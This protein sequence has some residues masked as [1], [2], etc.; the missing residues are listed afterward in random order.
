MSV[1][2]A[3]DSYYSENWPS[4]K[5]QSRFFRLRRSWKLLEIE[6]E[7]KSRRRGRRRSNSLKVHYRAI[8][9]PV[10][11]Q[12]G[13]GSVPGK[14]KGLFFY[15]GWNE[16]LSCTL[17]GGRVDT[18]SLFNRSTNPTSKAQKWEKC[19]KDYCFI[20]TIFSHFFSPLSLYFFLNLL[21][22]QARVRTHGERFGSRSLYVD[23]K[24]LVW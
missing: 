14:D 21:A 9:I 2:M 4:L 1:C 11:Y 7:R 19:R 5:N 3:R 8:W 20:T 16:K 18:R 15:C 22:F 24:N 23:F 6:E 13:S 10:C 12:R 17:L